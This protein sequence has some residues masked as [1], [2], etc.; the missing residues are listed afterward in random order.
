M[1]VIPASNKQAWK[2]FKDHQGDE[3]EEALHHEYFTGD[4]VSEDDYPKTEKGKPLDNT[5]THKQF[6]IRKA[7][8]DQIVQVELWDDR[9]DHFH[10]FIALAHEL[11]KSRHNLQEV[12]VH[13]VFPEYGVENP[14]VLNHHFQK[15]GVEFVKPLTI[16]Y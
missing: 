16:T 6:I 7:T 14:Y 15:D 9:K 13:Q 12:I 5:L 11:L 4:F 8:R 1:R 3:E 10:H 2:H